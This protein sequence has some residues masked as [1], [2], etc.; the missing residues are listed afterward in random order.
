VNLGVTC[1][2][3]WRGIQRTLWTGE[4]VED[5][6][7]IGD[8]SIGGAHRQLTVMLAG[9]NGPRLFVRESYRGFAAFR[10]NFI[11]LDRSELLALDA[12]VHRALERM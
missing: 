5:Y 1:V 10:V 8:R 4:I 9:K 7:T 12:I 2:G 3:L 6:G 11:E